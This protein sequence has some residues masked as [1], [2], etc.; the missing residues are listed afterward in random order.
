MPSRSAGAMHD[1]WETSVTR[2][3][4]GYTVPDTLLGTGSLGRDTVYAGLARYTL[5]PIGSTVSTSHVPDGR[6]CRCDD[7]RTQGS[8]AISHVNTINWSTCGPPFKGGRLLV[9]LNA[10]KAGKGVG[11]IRW[12]SR[13]S[14]PGQPTFPWAGFS[15]TPGCKSRAS[16]STTTAHRHPFSHIPENRQTQCG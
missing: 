10:A 2:D 4:R 1:A 9:L 14:E 13:L 5:G 16:L 12:S 7:T 11:E 8:C 15:G 3:C 6:A